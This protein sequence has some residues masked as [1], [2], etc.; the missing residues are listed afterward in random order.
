MEDGAS[1]FIG[2]IHS[3]TGFLILFRIFLGA[4]KFNSKDL[5]L[6]AKKFNSWRQE[7]E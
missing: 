6:G 1:C 7:F 4:K 5:I 3:S 2:V